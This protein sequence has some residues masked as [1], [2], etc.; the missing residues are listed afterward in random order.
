MAVLSALEAAP[1]TAAATLGA[2]RAT[3]AALGA[4][5]AA[6]AEAV[7]GAGGASG[8][9][10][11]GASGALHGF[12]PFEKVAIAALVELAPSVRALLAHSEQGRRLRWVAPAKRPRDLA[13]LI[14]AA[15]SGQIVALAAEKAGAATVAR[16][17]Y[18]RALCCPMANPPAF[19][20]ALALPANGGLVLGAWA[21]NGRAAGGILGP[22][23]AEKAT[24]R[25]AAGG[26]RGLGAASEKSS[27]RS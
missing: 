19:V 25:S 4:R 13:L 22:G 12:R 23:A 11:G 24:E 18:A 1:T 20:A 15:S 9:A 2:G 3:E 8:A 7:A 16:G 10:V 6:E 26:S 27:A 17:A 14:P 21:R 5:H